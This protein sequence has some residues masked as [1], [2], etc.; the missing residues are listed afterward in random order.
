MKALVKKSVIAASI[1]AAMMV[2]GA[3]SAATANPFTVAGN[4]TFTATSITGYYNETITFNTNGTFDVALLFTA[5]AFNNNG[6]SVAAFTSGLSSSY[7]LYAIYNV[8]GTYTPQADGTTKFNFTPSSGGISLYKDTDLSSYSGGYTAPT[9]GKGVYTVAGESSDTLLATGIAMD[10]SNG[11]LDPTGATCGSQG[12]NCGSFGSTTSLTLTAAGSQFFTTPSPFY[13]MSF[14][15][16]VL[17]SFTATGTQV[18]PGTL[19]VVFNTAEVPEPASLGLLGLG[20]L[21][22]GIAR[23][24]KQN[25]A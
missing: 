25:Q 2:G 16:G 18:I 20:L 1:A 12:I 19:N 14:Q 23:R 6:K 9:D 22:L 11:T 17:T 4:T 5:D 8:S 7:G 15:S 13:N 3:A 21:G 10:P 24:R